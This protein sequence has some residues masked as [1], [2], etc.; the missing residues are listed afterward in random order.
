ERVD[1]REFVRVR[2]GRGW[3]VDNPAPCHFGARQQGT[4]RE[5]GHDGGRKLARIPARRL[6]Q[7][8]REVGG[9]LAVLVVA[10]ALDDH[11][12]GSGH[13]REHAP[14]ELAQGGQQQLLE[15]LLQEVRDP[16]VWQARKWSRSAGN[17]RTADARALQNSSIGST[18]SDQRTRRALG[19]ATTCASQVSRNSCRRERSGLST[20]SCAW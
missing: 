13:L 5:R 18:S 2:L 4:R 19:R 17:I 15:F 20:S 7:P 1:T 6:R 3:K 12:G 9:E 8:Q 10:G 14:G 16:R 11:R